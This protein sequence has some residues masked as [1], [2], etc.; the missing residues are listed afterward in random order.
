MVIIPRNF[1]FAAAPLFG[2]HIILCGFFAINCAFV[3][4]R[5]AAYTGVFDKYLSGHSLEPAI[6]T[7][8]VTQCAA[9]C[10]GKEGCLSV[11]FDAQLNTCQLNEASAQQFQD[12]LVS[13]SGVTY[14]GLDQVR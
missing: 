9:L 12:D 13:K 11:N 1:V 14:Y 7:S 3:N 5:S 8:S 6:V 10:L 2:V 4:K